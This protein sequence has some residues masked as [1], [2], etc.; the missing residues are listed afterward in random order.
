[1][2]YGDYQA[3]LKG[4][5][6]R[7]PSQNSFD[8]GKID[9]SECTQ[10]WFN[11]LV[12]H[13]HAIWEKDLIYVFAIFDK[14]GK[15]IGMLNL[16]TLARN[17]LLWGELGYVIHNQFWKMG[18]AFESL[19]ALLDKADSVFN[20]HRIEANIHPDNTI[21][22]SLIQKLGFCYECRREKFIYENNQW[23]D[24]DIYYKNLY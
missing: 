8:D 7:K 17:D 13:Q 18:Y 15:H 12:D 4:F 16:A 23:V 22:K 3:W 5:L 20:Y 1:M 14:F 11:H 6:D 21:S 2:Q 10:E 9:M 24:R 19:I